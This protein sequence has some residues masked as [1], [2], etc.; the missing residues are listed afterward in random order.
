[1]DAPG[2]PESIVRAARAARAVAV[3]TGAG[4]SA[5]SG[6]PTFRGSGG[7]WRSWKPEDLATAEAFARD[8]QTVWA[9]YRWRQRL[10]AGAQPNEG[11]L[12]LARCAAS[13]PGW[14]IVTQNVDGLHQRAGSSGVVELHGSIWRLQCREGCGREAHVE[15]EAVPPEEAPLPHCACGAL[16][17]PGVVWFGEAL[18]PAVVADAERLTQSADVLLVIGTSAVVYPAAALPDRARR[19]GALVVE[20]NPAPTAFSDRADFVVRASAVRALTALERAL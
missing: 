5:E 11:H 8:P 13:R 2:L 4:M 1:M 17:R 6:V 18:D 14:R 19:Q 7:L 15:P 16:Q 10:I 9:W 12:A 20:I 3:L